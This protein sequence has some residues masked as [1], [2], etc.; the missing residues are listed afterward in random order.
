M[1]A[2]GKYN[3]HDSRQKL[4]V[5]V[6][7]CGNGDILVFFF[8]DGN[9]NVQSYLIRLNDVVIL[10]MTLSLVTPFYF[11][12]WSYLEDKVFRTPLESLNFL[13]QR[14]ITECNKMENSDL[15][16]RFVQHMRSRADTCA[17][18]SEVMLWGWGVRGNL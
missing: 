14:I 4:T 13:Q 2:P 7:L 3:V 15:I 18:R 6:G 16:R 17:Q 5:W 11:F 1:Y 10:S 9:V 8:F 12:L